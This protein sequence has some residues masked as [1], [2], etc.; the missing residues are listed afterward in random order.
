M[1]GKKIFWVFGALIFGTIMISLYLWATQSL[2]NWLIPEIFHGPRITFG[3]TAGLMLLVCMFSWIAIGG[4]HRH[5]PDR[6]RWKN[7]WRNKWRQGWREEWC[8]MSEEER[9][10]WK[11]RFREMG[12]GGMD[13]E[14][15]Q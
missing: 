10:E 3:Q 8:R 11:K 1:K 13:I 6:M 7:K 4:R 15:Q 14:E 5:H 9:A 2:W 12:R